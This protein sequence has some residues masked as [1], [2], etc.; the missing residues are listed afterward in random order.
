[1]N[2]LLIV[3]MFV[4]KT[5]IYDYSIKDVNGDTIR[6]SSFQGK[7]MLLVNIAS[8]S[9]HVNQ[10]MELQQLHQLYKDSVVII[11]FPS[12]SFAKEIRNDFE[13]KQFCQENFGSS[14]IIASKGMVTG[15]QA[16]PI[17][18]WLSHAS[19][20]GEIDAPIA[21]DFQKFIIG[22][23]G[24]IIGIFRHSVNPL[25]PSIQNILKGN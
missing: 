2:I 4:F 14:F 9:E 23:E 11:A 18:Y 21:N 10:L 6:L 5:S 20:N 19:E 17:Y 12:N 7:K 13:I 1:M 25:N 8:E 3:S 15:I 24:D 16:Q 22:K